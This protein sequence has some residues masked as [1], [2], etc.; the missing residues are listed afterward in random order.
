M[1]SVESKPNV[2]IAILPHVGIAK[3]H[4]LRAITLNRVL[5]KTFQTR[6][7]VPTS[8]SDFVHQHFPWLSCDWIDWQYGHNDVLD[9]LLSEVV[10]RMK[11]TATN[12]ERILNTVSADVVIGIPGFQSSAICRAIG[13]RHISLL[14]G[15]W[16]LP[17]YRLP[18][19]SIGEGAVIKSW[20]TSI[21]ITDTLLK[22]VAQTFG[23][24]DRGYEHWLENETVLIAQDFAG[25]EYTARRPCVG[26]LSGDY[27]PR[28]CYD[29][30]EKALC[31]ILGSALD[32]LREDLLKRLLQCS[33]PVVIVGGSKKRH[34]I[35]TADG[36][37]YYTRT[38][39]ATVLARIST[40]AVC[41]GGIG[42]IPLFAEVGARQLFMPHDLDQAVNTILA[43]R[44][45]YGV[46]I[47]LRYWS[48]RTPFGRIKP[49]VNK[50]AFN[51]LLEILP[52]H[53]EPLQSVPK[54]NDLAL[55]HSG[56][57]EV[58]P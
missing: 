4:L 2:R 40:M 36:S 51:N 14:H 34:R 15:P 57:C 42:T 5:K 9:P 48:K 3:G 22:I 53:R 56:I 23:V 13:I 41:H 18:D 24:K 30:P 54:V 27:G 1:G 58:L 37:I 38:R 28:D 25:V 20:K 19:L 16:L 52:R 10:K 26:F 21:E 50:S 39:A 17:E 31:V 32:G 45:G 43:V 8:A 44:S 6:L 55:I 46:T 29:L 7:I 47:D 11:R 33:L 49:P 12:L 35:S